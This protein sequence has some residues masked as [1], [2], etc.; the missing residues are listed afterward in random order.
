MARN[1][2]SGSSSET[3]ESTDE[4]RL[5]KRKKT[6]PRLVVPPPRP[7]VKEVKDTDKHAA[8][9]AQQMRMV[10]EALA[11]QSESINKVAI[12]ISRIGEEVRRYVSV[13]T[14]QPTP[15]ERR[16]ENRGYAAQYHRGSHY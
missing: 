10:A 3:D 14:T 4:E 5:V 11:R 7:P 9:F 15:Q 8:D 1:T 13:N 2:E 6:L 12:S 16:T